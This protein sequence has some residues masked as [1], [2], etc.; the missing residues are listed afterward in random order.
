LVLSPDSLTVE[1]LERHLF[2]GTL[3]TPECHLL[4]LEKLDEIEDAVAQ[5]YPRVIVVDERVGEDACEIAAQFPHDVPV[6]VCSIPSEA[7]A[8]LALG[9][10]R[11]LRKPIDEEQLLS[12][13]EALGPQVKTILIIDDDR[14]MVRLLSR[15]LENAPRSY[16][17]LEA[18]DADEGLTLMRQTHPD[19][20]LLDILMP[21]KDGFE[22][23]REVKNDPDL[24]DIP[25][26]MISGTGQPA[27]KPSTFST[28]TIAR[29]G[30]LT[31]EQIT[32]GLRTVLTMMPPDYLGL[33]TIAPK[34]PQASAG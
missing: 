30:R 10:T 14:W 20:I 18:F 29:K 16:R 1:V 12:A 19:A 22:T 4:H 5:L 17:L 28:F 24:D 23:L 31:I 2:K 15:M 34:L 25:I 7:E 32:A 21:G 11:H 33:G 9:A 3:T 26:I 8:S 27:T 13:V 6:I